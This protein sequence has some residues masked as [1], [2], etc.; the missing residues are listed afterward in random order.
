MMYEL[1]MN[2]SGGGLGQVAGE[3]GFGPLVV[4]YYAPDQGGHAAPPAPSSLPLWQM[5][6]YPDKATWKHATSSGPVAAPPIVSA[7]ATSDESVWQ[8]LG[9]PSKDAWRAAG[10]P[11]L[12][13]G[14]PQKPVAAPPTMVGQ[15][16]GSPVPAPPG[17]AGGS[18]VPAPTTQLASPTGTPSAAQPG[19]IPGTILG[20]PANYLLIGGAVLLLVVV[21]GKR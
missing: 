2:Y 18:P 20:L 5:L 17:S 16:T 9:F 8:L 1:A 4:P 13:T 14:T 21:M 6:G 12:T 15:P 3:P 10:K 19:A 11:D 7:T